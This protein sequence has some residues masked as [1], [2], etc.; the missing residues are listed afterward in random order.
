MALSSFLTFSSL[1]A[2]CYCCCPLLWFSFKTQV[3][4]TLV[5]QRKG[6]RLQFFFELCYQSFNRCRNVTL[7]S[8]ALF[9]HSIK[10]LKRQVK[11]FIV[12]GTTGSKS[13]QWTDVAK[14]PIKG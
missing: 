1:V 11:Q 9:Q 5:T 14:Y 6:L 12:T 4:P 2:V 10:H 3:L 7:E 8:N 13:T